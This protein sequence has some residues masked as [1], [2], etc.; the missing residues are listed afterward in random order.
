MSLILQIFVL[1]SFIS[2]FFN[3]HF[4]LFLS[5]FQFT[6]GPNATNGDL[7]LDYHFK[8]VMSY[9]QIVEKTTVDMIPKAITFYIIQNVEKFINVGLSNLAPNIVSSEAIA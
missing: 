9:M 8:Q 5:P 6:L 4:C 3:L 2:L 1:H 7:N